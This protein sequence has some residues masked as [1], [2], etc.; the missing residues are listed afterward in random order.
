MGHTL[1]GLRSPPQQCAQHCRRRRG[2]ALAARSLGSL[3][4]Y[5]TCGRMLTRFCPRSQIPHPH[6]W[7]TFQNIKTLSQATL[8]ERQ[9]ISFYHASLA[10]NPVQ[11]AELKCCHALS[12][13][14]GTA[15]IN[16]EVSQRHCS[17]SVVAHS[18]ARP[19]L[20]TRVMPTRRALARPRAA[21]LLASDRAHTRR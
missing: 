5:Q 11:P 9:V 13:A 3:K 21:R 17:H 14:K 7:K 12:C 1:P 8:K 18:A 2:A 19:S 15:L 6:T 20:W 10:T 16:A 4:P